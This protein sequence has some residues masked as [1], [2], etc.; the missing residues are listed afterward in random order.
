MIYSDDDGNTWSEPEDLNPGLKKEWMKFFG[1]A[2]GKGIQIKN[3]E[4]KG[5]LVFPIYYTNQ[6]NFQSSAVIYSDDFGE[7]WKLGE[8]PIDTASVSSE[9]VSSGTQLTEC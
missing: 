5:R 7:T 9:T 3:G 2:P 1:T 8:S 4:H 6:N